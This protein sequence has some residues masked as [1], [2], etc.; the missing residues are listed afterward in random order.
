VLGQQGQQGVAGDDVLG[1][2]CDDGGAEARRRRDDAGAASAQSAVMASVVLALA[3]R[4][5]IGA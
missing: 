5:R 4:M 1:A 2:R 3:T